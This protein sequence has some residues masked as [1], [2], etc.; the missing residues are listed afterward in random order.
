MLKRIIRNSAYMLFAEGF[1]KVLMFILTVL[2]ARALGVEKFG[3]YSFTF[4]YALLFGMLIDFG[5]PFAYLKNIAQNKKLKREYLENILSLKFFLAAG[6]IVLMIIVGF[7]LKKSILA[8]VLAGIFVSI[9]MIDES[10]KV[11]FRA[12]EQLKFEAIAKIVEKSL[13]FIIAMIA[14]FGTILGTISVEKIFFF[15]LLAS[16]IGLFVTIYYLRRFG[17]TKLLVN[18]E[19]WKIFLREGL[20]FFFIVAFTLVSER[21]ATILLGI[22]KTEEAVGLFSAPNQ[23]VLAL[24]IIPLVLVKAVLPRFTSLHQRQIALKKVFKKIFWASLLLG[25]LVS[26]AIFIA[27]PLLIKTLYGP[28]FDKSVPVLQ[29]L[30]WS[31]F[32]LSFSTIV[33]YF[34]IAVNEQKFVVKAAGFGAL[35][36]IVLNLL[37]IPRYS[38]IGAAIATVGTQILLFIVYCSKAKALIR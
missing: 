2:F 17:K 37:L 30:V 12:Y 38:F 15:Y 33:S 23:I 6:V 1:A 22:M 14:I 7:I 4:A 27:S 32:V 13:F 26:I 19:K 8:I 36:G 21:I 10:L 18:I 34:V 11:I 25:G 29:I 5:I 24:G 3:L 16:L 9:D 28:E 35:V 20:P 31:F